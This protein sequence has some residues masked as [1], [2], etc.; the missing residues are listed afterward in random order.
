LNYK[1]HVSKRPEGERSIPE[2]T[3]SHL[4]LAIVQAAAFKHENLM[5]I[6]EYIELYHDSDETGL[7]L[8][9]EPF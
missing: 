4:P 8:L 1:Q 2:W 5:S 9:S 7:D 3:I 6:S